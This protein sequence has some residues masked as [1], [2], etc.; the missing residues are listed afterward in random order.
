MTITFNT[1]LLPVPGFTDML[2]DKDYPKAV[3]SVPGT[4]IE[5]VTYSIS[6]GTDQFYSH[7]KPYIQ[8]RVIYS[9]ANPTESNNL[10][11]YFAKGSNK[12]VLQVQTERNL[13]ILT[14]KV[15]DL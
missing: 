1:N 10:A 4:T 6:N 14:Y 3:F 11:K 5:N 12:A 9:T 15:Q 2:I 8:A 13:L 7:N